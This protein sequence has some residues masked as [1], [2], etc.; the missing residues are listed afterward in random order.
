MALSHLTGST[1]RTLCTRNK[2]YSSLFVLCSFHVL[3]LSGK[4]AR[5]RRFFIANTLILWGIHFHRTGDFATRTKICYYTA[6]YVG[7]IRLNVTGPLGEMSKVVW[8]SQTENRMSNPNSKAG[9]PVDDIWF[10]S[11][12]F[13]LRVGFC[14]L[15]SR[16]LLKFVF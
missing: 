15:C 12:I 6:I 8:F 2:C 7:P 5:V 11:Y 16:T 9:I 10:D 3:L 4:C 1:V 13:Y 14:N